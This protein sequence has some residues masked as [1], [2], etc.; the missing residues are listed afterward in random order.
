MRRLGQTDDPK[1]AARLGDYLLARGVRTQTDGDTMWVL[2]EDRVE[3][4][5]AEFAAFEAEPD[6]PKY[7]AASQAAAE[8]REQELKAE[9][10][11]RKLRMKTRTRYDRPQIA[12]CGQ[13]LLLIGLSILATFI[14]EFGSQ[15]KDLV[16][17]LQ[18]SEVAQPGP[19]GFYGELPEVGRGEIQRLI[20]PIFPHGSLMHLVF[21]MMWL[22][23]LGPLVEFRRGPFRFLTLVLGIAVI[24]NV[25]QFMW[26]GPRF[27]GMS[28]VVAGLFGYAWIY[29]RLADEGLRLNRETSALMLI[30]LF[31]VAIVGPPGIANAAHLAGLF[32]GITFAYSDVFIAR[33]LRR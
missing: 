14:T 12:R 7:A 29:G 11:R 20:T 8:I 19:D 30:Y 33:A 15:R 27:Y 31:A 5:R 23:S 26:A 1:A 25:A 6:A 32:A 18:I 24:S 13:T 28:G 9:I 21:N 22:F 16:Q 10:E 3:E 17:R 2:D 4:A